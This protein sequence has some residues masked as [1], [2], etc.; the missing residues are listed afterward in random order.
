MYDSFKF[1]ANVH[2]TSKASL[3]GLE[4]KLNISQGNVDLEHSVIILVMVLPCFYFINR[5][6]DSL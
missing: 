1:H 5:R 4:F 6:Y 2:F 3:F